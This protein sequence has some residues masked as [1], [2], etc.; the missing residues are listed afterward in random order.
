MN[1]AAQRRLT[2]PLVILALL[3]GALLLALFAGIGRGIRW[4]APRA[5]APLPDRQARKLPPVAPLEQFAAVWKKPLFSPDRK[6]VARA[7]GEGNLGDL[8]LTGI[9]LTRDLR[10][11]LLRDKRG[12]TFRV[13]E[14]GSLPDG[15]WT[16]AEL[17]PRSALFDAP[18]GRTELQL[19]AGAPID[20]VAREGA[21]A[22]SAPDTAGRPPPARPAP[23]ATPSPQPSGSAWVAGGDGAARPLREAA[24]LQAQRVKQL[25]AAIQKR[26]AEQAR[27]GNE[28][29]R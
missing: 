19:P 11:A 1:A 7:A 27:T 24:A 25:K 15:S 28:G 9:I 13:R 3:L 8:Q 26:R 2:P 10:M 16:L 14:G 12:D 17:K 18:S 5:S 22:P 6:P 4:D 29:D 21:A 20:N 23:A